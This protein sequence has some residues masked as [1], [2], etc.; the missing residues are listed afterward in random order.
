VH[1]DFEGF[2]EAA[3]NYRVVMKGKPI[4]LYNMLRIRARYSVNKSICII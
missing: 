2:F 4:L 3:L 1:E